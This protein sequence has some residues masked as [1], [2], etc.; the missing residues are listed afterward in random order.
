MKRTNLVLDA[1]LLDD[2]LKAS[3]ARTYS[4]A[5]EMAM[6]EFVRR[7]RART[8]LSL[9]G[10]GLWHGDLSTVREDRPAYQVRR[11]RRP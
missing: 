2:T 11:R 10:S 7:A 6:Q 5:V 8:I 4:A 9:Q 1:Q 3:G